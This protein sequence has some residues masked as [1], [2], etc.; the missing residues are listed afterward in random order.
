MTSQNLSQ[1]RL[2]TVSEVLRR[3]NIPRH[4]LVYLFD[5]RRLK[6]EDFLK[7]PNGHRIFRESDINQIRLALFE[8]QVR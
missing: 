5:S 3:L 7:L 8:V 2:Y 4:K 6:D 1:E